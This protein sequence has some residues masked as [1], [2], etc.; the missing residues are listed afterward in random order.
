M[1]DYTKKKA[2]MTKT[3]LI[4]V[5]AELKKKLAKKKLNISEICRDALE[6][7]VKE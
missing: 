2:E 5:P 4:R 1:K 3:I 7:Q 6:K